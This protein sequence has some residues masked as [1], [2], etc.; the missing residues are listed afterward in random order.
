[1]TDGAQATAVSGAG[2][3]SIASRFRRRVADWGLLRAVHFHVMNALARIAGLHV[4]CVSVDA[5]SR[6]LRYQTP[7]RTP[8]GYDTRFVDVEDLLPY[9]DRTTGL[10]GDFVKRAIE[11]GYLCVA[12][13]YRGEIVGY[14]FQS[15]TRAPVTD[16]LDV[17][18]PTG[19]RYGFKA[20]THPDHRRRKLGEV[21]T[22]VQFT[23]GDHPPGERSVHYIECHNYPSLLHGYRHPRER[24]IRIG[25]VGWITVFGRHIPFNS[26]GAKWLGFLFVRREDTRPRLYVS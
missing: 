15:R 26:R 25:L 23:Y 22:Y 13:F 18:V 5:A 1:M 14:T 11:A 19:F 17:I 21:R 8:P 2:D 16:Q 3:L 20:W 10:D 6:E 12:N 24:R 7:P 9:A 4:H